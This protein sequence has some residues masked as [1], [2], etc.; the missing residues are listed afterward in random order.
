MKKLKLFVVFLFGV[1]AFAQDPQTQETDTSRMGRCSMMGMGMLMPRIVTNLPDGSILVQSGQKLIKYDQ[2][3][4]LVKEVTVPVDTAS[5]KHFQMM[6]PRTPP[7]QPK[8]QGSPP[9]KK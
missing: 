7:E 4:N 9:P 2:N 3:L 6:C 5:I 1:T 8:K